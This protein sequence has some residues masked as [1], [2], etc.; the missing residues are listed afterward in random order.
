MDNIVERARA[1]LKHIKDDGDAVL[2]DMLC[3]IS[4]SHQEASKRL[5]A[6][7]AKLLD[8]IERLRAALRWIRDEGDGDVS[9]PVAKEALND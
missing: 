8:E 3:S 5:A 1:R 2:I 7:K 4:L 6:D 9:R